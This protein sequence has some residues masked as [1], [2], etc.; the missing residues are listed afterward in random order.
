MKHSVS[1]TNYETRNASN[2]LRNTQHLIHTLLNTYHTHTHTRARARARHFPAQERQLSTT[3][4]SWVG[5]GV[6]RQGGGVVGGPL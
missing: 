1:N 4:E 2:T 6:G 5:L 3:L